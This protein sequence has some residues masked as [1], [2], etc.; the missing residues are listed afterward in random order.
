MRFLRSMGLNCKITPTLAGSSLT[1]T[2]ALES[3][4][5]QQLRMMWQLAAAI[6]SLAESARQPF[7]LEV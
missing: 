5:S 2:P 3:A 4:F 6:L 1:F 7:R